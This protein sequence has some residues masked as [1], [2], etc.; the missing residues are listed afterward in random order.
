MSKM[1]LQLQNVFIAEFIYVT[2]SKIYNVM[3]EH[4]F[5]HSHMVQARI[6]SSVL[7]PIVTRKTNLIFNNPCSTTTDYGD[8]RTNQK[9]FKCLNFG[10]QPHNV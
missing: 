5:L 9:A 3:N 8:V 2:F 4:S 6:V 1:L 10:S 7:K